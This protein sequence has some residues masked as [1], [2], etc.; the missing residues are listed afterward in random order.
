MVQPNQEAQP[1]RSSR[2]RRGEEQAP[3]VDPRLAV[4]ADA[5]LEGE[6]GERSARCSV[7]DRVDHLHRHKP[8]FWA[9]NKIIKT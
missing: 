4:T 9:R 5:I 7:F 2:P 6:A 1:R 3:L 8:H